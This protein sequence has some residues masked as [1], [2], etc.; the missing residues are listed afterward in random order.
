MSK[1]T[2]TAEAIADEALE[3]VRYG[4]EQTRWIGAL[5]KAITLDMEHNEGR[6]VADLASLG[7]YLSYDCTNYQDSEAERLQREL[8]ALEVMA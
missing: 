5:M 4:K 2:R 3:A 1:I 8:D 6:M 7:H